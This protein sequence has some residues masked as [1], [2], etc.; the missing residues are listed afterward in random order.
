MVRPAAGTRS[1]AD[2]D[3]WN[4]RK[5]KDGIA[6]SSWELDI[7]PPD[8]DP[9]PERSLNSGTE[10]YARF[11]RRLAEGDWF[12]I[13]YGCLIASGIDNLL[14]A[15]RCIS[16]GYLA[17]SS[18]R[19]QQTCMST[20]QAAGTAAALSLQSDT[21]PRQLDPADVVT[22]LKRDREVEPV[23]FPS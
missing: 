9:A 8:D 23:D 2:D 16:A 19:I 15:G 21:V 20:G 6:R 22:H 13:P 1:H 5:A 4:L 17:Q 18:L 11:A 14:V 12:D 7:H 10:A 3:A